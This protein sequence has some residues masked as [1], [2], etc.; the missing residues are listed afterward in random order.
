MTLQKADH[1]FEIRRRIA[2]FKSRLAERRHEG[3]QISS[4]G[5]EQLLFELGAI[6]ALAVELTNEV[7]LHRRAGTSQLE[8]RDAITAAVISAIRSKDSNVRL[9]P[10]IA[11]PISD[12]GAR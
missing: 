10:V 8:N 5:V 3:A 6:E 2:T 7:S 4:E 12:G 9:F 11:R 1:L